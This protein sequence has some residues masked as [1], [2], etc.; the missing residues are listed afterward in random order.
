LISQ[1]LFKRDQELVVSDAVEKIRPTDGKRFYK[2]VEII[3]ARKLWL[4]YI[5]RSI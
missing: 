5:P 2:I 3:L 4:G 1:L